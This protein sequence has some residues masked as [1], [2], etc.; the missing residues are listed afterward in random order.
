M[1]RSEAIYSGSFQEMGANGV[2]I[3][4]RMEMTKRYR[5]APSQW[6]PMEQ[7]K[8]QNEGNAHGNKSTQFHENRQNI[9]L[10]LRT[11]I[12]VNQI[13]IYGEIADLCKEWTKIQLK[14]HTKIQ[15]ARE[16]SIQKKDQMRC[17]LYAENL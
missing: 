15:K 9:E 16:H 11:V 12:S 14:I 10:L 3:E 1:A 7:R 5:R 4:E 17:K 2:N 8:C 13:N 6:K